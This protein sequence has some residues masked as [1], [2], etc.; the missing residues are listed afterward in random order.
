MGVTLNEGSFIAAGSVVT[1]ECINL[2]FGW[3]YTGKGDK[4]TEHIILE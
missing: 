3:W 2:Y 1:G 4:E